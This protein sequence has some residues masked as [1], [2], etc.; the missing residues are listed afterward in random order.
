MKKFL[1]PVM[2]GIFVFTQTALA[3][4]V[5]FNIDSS[6]DISGRSGIS[7][8]EHH[9]GTNSRWFVADDY[10]NSLSGG[11][12]DNLTAN[13]KILSNEFDEVIYPRLRA[14]FGSEN[15]PGV[16]GDPKITILVLEMIEEAGGYMREQDGLAQDKIIGSNGREMVYLNA[17]YLGNSRAKSFLAHEFQ[18]LI[19]FNQKFVQYNVQEEVWLNELRS[20]IAS[21]IL[22]YDNPQVYGGSNLE[23][24]VKNFLKSPSDAVLEWENKSKDYSTINLLGQ[25]ILDYYGRSVLAAMTANNKVGI[26]SFN[27][28]LRAFGFSEDFSE[29]FKNWT[30]AALV[31]DCQVGPKLCY[32]N[33]NLDFSNFHIQFNIIEG[34]GEK[35]TSQSQTK[36]WKADWL[37][38][39]KQLNA[40]KPQEHIFMLQFFAAEASKFRI[41]YVVYDSGGKVMEVGEIPIDERESGTLFVE[42]FGFSVPKIVIIPYNQTQKVGTNG[43]ALST[44][45]TFNASTIDDATRQ[46]YF[47]PAAPNLL[48]VPAVST[49][50]PNLADGSLIR[51]EGDYKVYI[52]KDGYKRWLQSAEIFNFYGH[53]GFEVVNVLPQDTVALYKDAWLVR[54]EGDFKVYEINGDG[55]RHWLDISAEEFNASGRSWDMIY[56]I[57]KAELNWYQE[58]ASVK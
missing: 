28:A 7:A 29:V 37:K 52:I 38:L 57:N 30:L 42:N 13:I 20:E 19:T 53:L 11:A 12:K 33:P 47:T 1:I 18:H 43:N 21:T 32:K 48:E 49:S 41:P 8:S 24:R 55:T 17:A 26:E 6:Y 58:G 56:V 14:L 34:S 54:A 9:A 2:I 50:L 25:Y 44:T 23:A 46:T 35:I 16:D 31:N 39:E 40:E 10:W 36:D 22:G 27:E 5:S 51:A 4:S 3:Q 45:Y 15:T